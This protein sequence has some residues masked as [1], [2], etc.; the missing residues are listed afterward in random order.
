MTVVVSAVAAIVGWGYQLRQRR[1]VSNASASGVECPALSQMRPCGALSP[2]EC[3]RWHPDPVG[4]CQL[5]GNRSC[6]HGH[7]QLIYRCRRI[8]DQVNH[9]FYVFIDWNFESN[10]YAGT[11]QSIQSA[12]RV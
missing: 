9:N 7:Q 1:I 4:P 3:A 11:I 5:S 10:L 2:S 6:G 12:N 8:F